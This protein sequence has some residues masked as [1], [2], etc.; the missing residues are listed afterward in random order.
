V[1][2]DSNGGAD[3]WYPEPGVDEARPYAVADGGA[4]LRD[5][6]QRAPLS[7]P[8]LFKPEISRDPPPAANDNNKGLGRAPIGLISRLWPLLLASPPPVTDTRMI[9]GTN[10]LALVQVRV[11]NEDSGVVAAFFAR[12]DQNQEATT[13]LDVPVKIK[14]GQVQYDPE[15]LLRAYG[16][17]VPGWTDSDP[18][19]APTEPV[20]GVQDPRLAPTAPERQRVDPTVQP[21]GFVPGNLTPQDGDERMLIEVLRHAGVHPTAIAGELERL[22]AERR[23]NSEVGGAAARYGSGQTLIKALRESGATPEQIEEQLRN[24]WAERRADAVTSNPRNQPGD[25]HAS[26]PLNRIEG[27]WLRG[28][29]GNAGQIPAQVAEKLEGRHFA[30]FGEFRAAFWRTVADTPELASQF[31]P[32]NR[33]LMRDG[34]APIAVEDQWHGGMQYVLHHQTPIAKGGEVYDLSNLVVLTP[35]MHQDILARDYHFGR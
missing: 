32:G 1:K 20:P 22:R 35:R 7:N 23:D 13:R 15:A 11:S 14:N 9:P 17:P 10:D 31:S 26:G 6:L 18:T 19:R 3:S 8:E 27:T 34:L 2:V 12:T 16:R 33:A 24:D 4:A 29:Q 30:N 5:T 25:A 28:T 21:P